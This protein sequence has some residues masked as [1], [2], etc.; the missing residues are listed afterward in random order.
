M[1]AAHRPHPVHLQN[2]ALATTT[3]PQTSSASGFL[4]S[5]RPNTQPSREAPR[6]N[7]STSERLSSFL[8]W[9]VQ[10]SDPSASHPFPLLRSGEFPHL[11]IGLSSGRGC[12]EAE[13]WTRPSLLALWS[14]QHS[15]AGVLSE[16]QNL[17]AHCGLSESEPVLQW[18][19][20]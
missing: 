9:A 14:A 17:G 10:H 12:L 6:L 7:R 5:R 18:L 2:P 19:L 16:M 15:P 13:A 1:L 3:L 8:D 11:K 20:K 4:G